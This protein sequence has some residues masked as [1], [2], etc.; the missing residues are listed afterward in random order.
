MIC[1]T[2]L[3]HKLWLRNLSFRLGLHH[4]KV[5]GS[6]STALAPQPWLHSPGSTAH[7]AAKAAYFAE[8][9]CI[10]NFEF[11]ECLKIFPIFSDTWPLQ[12]S[13]FFYKSYS[14]PFVTGTCHLKTY[15]NHFLISVMFV[16]A[17]VATS[18]IVMGIHALTWTSASGP[19][20]SPPAHK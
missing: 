4:L 5:F 13:T 2:C 14:A 18:F 20:P 8:C 12:K 1:A 19:H 11:C 6:D 16:S 9:G 17:R 7:S 10:E 15:I 3:P